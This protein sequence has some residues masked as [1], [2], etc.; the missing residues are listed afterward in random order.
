MLAGIA[1]HPQKRNL[2][3]EL[4]DTCVLVFMPEQRAAFLEDLITQVT[5][6]NAILQRSPLLGWRGARVGVILVLCR[7]HN[8]RADVWLFLLLDLTELGDITIISQYA[9]QHHSTD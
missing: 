6:V 8:L 1:R 7:T 4:K 5:G 3:K 9:T 2:E